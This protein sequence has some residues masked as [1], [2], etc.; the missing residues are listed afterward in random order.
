ML[1][2]FFTLS[3][4]AFSFGHFVVRFSPLD[5]DKYINFFAFS[6]WVNRKNIV[7]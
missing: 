6:Q 4:R 1:V 3:F 7:K 2:R 5:K